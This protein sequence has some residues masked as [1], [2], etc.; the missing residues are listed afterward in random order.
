MNSSY[1]SGSSDPQPCPGGKYC[2]IAGLAAPTENCTAGFYCIL[3]ATLATPTD[4][5]TGDLCPAGYYCVS[6]SAAPSPCSPGTY[7]GS[8]HNTDPADCV[9]C[10][11]GEYCGDYNLTLT[12]GQL[13]ALF[14]LGNTLSF[15]LC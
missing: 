11:F 6:G 7:S 9:T 1:P 14:S 5:T 12:S 15:W 4:G 8:T 2:H 10:S 13:L 3:K